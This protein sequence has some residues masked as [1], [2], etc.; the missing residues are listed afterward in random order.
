VAVNLELK[1]RISSRK[2]IETIVRSFARRKFVLRQT[3]TYFRVKNGR[4]KLRVINERTAELI[5][6]LRDESTRRRWSTYEIYPI[7]SPKEIK[8]ILSEALGALVEVKKKRTLWV[9]KNARIHVDEVANLGH[10]MEFEVM[11]VKGKKQAL[12]LFNELVTRFG[13]QPNQMIA[14]SY[15]D[16]LLRAARQLQNFY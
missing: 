6:Y 15:S 9:Y 5:F 10:F 2:Q 3:D 7:Q 13:I 11:V 8:K 14:E 4:L 12:R 16:L 1:A